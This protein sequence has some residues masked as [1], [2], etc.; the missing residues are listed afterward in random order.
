MNPDKKI[1]NLLTIEAGI[2]ILSPVPIITFYIGVV[3]SATNNRIHQV[4]RAIILNQSIIDELPK[5]KKD[6]VLT[7]IKKTLHSKSRYFERIEPNFKKLMGILNPPDNAIE[8]KSKETTPTNT[9]SNTS[10]SCKKCFISR[11]LCQRYI[12][13]TQSTKIK[14]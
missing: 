12:G 4:E 1:F 9:N 11:L 8:Q 5:S 6:E 14:D 10:Y 7:L 3:I 13:A 2:A